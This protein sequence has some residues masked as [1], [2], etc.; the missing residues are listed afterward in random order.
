MFLE[1]CWL[2]LIVGA[3]AGAAVFHYTPRPEPIYRTEVSLL[4]ESK[5]N[6]VLAMQE[7][8]DTTLQGLSELNNH[9]EQ[10][11]SKTFI[12]Y[13]LGSFSPEEITRIQQAYTDPLKPNAPVPAL[14]DIVQGN[15]SINPR[16]GTTILGISVTN[17]SPANAALIAN[18][19]ARKYIDFSLDRASTGTSSA[20]IFLR[21]QAEETRAEVEAAEA[22]LQAF[23]AKYSMA[24]LGETKDVTVQK[25]ASLGEASV[26]AQLVQIQNKALIDKI[27]EYQQKGRDLM[28][29]AP[30]GGS[31]EVT[32]AKA[33]LATLASQRQSLDQRYLP[34]HPRILENERET[35]EARRDFDEGL[36]RAIAN[37][38]ANYEV[39][40]QHL[41]RLQSEMVETE[42]QV[43]SLD[44]IS[45]DYK[46]LEQDAAA[47]RATYNSIASRLS[48][49]KITSQLENTTIKVF[50]A[51]PVPNAPMDRGT[52]RIVSTSFA[53]FA[54]VTVLL[55]LVIGILDTRIRSPF[56]VEGSLRESLLG[57]IKPLPKSASFTAATSFRS[58]GD[59][60]LVES[61]RGIYSEI[62]LRSHLAYPKVI[63]I[64]SCVP[65]EGKTQVACNLTSVF[66]AHQRRVLLVDCDLRRPGIHRE[67]K[68][69]GESGWT[70]WIEQPAA[71]R[72]KVPAAVTEIEP[73]FDLLPAGRRI[74]NPTQQIESLG[75]KEV[76]Q[77]LLERYDVVLFDTP[78]ATVFP[79]PLLLAR[80]CHEL[81][82]VVGYKMIRAGTAHRTL[83]RFAETGVSKLGVVI[84]RLPDAK[85][86]RYGDYLGY[87]SYKAKYY[88]SY[89][90]RSPQ[91]K[92][93]A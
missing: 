65:S 59:A 37:L 80:S 55:P 41:Q 72:P 7:V 26:T 1:R 88:K 18:R 67:F 12:D 10:M 4:F 11:R 3:A 29:I 93:E 46:F 5:R 48:E 75:R 70:E 57:A 23:R 76:L 2:G 61:W 83:Q 9:L 13:L 52:A 16:R 36:A 8:V 66:A 6:R 42:V 82:F 54:F 91:A 50:D 64:S 21:S 32:G 81:V 19:Y 44:K 47:K 34:R 58:G 38:K 25:L 90:E 39:A 62:E 68:R 78:P 31:L 69:S 22:A 84:N 24:T 92:Q 71:T 17:R 73:Y 53:T 14:A 49:A 28:E 40:A 56:H 35:R 51:A 60:G 27:A 20:I 15:V 85:L 63:L 87:G 77:G 86:I 89:G 43:R 45:V 79:D 74:A 30:I 33:R